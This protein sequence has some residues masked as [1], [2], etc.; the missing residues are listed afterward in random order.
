M[1]TV[2]DKLNELLEL[3]PL[4]LKTKELNSLS[5][6][7]LEYTKNNID[8]MKTLIE[9]KLFHDGELHG[10]K[11]KFKLHILGYDST[12]QVKISYDPDYACIT[13][14]YTVGSF[15]KLTQTKALIS[16][17]GRN[18]EVIDESEDLF[19]AIRTDLEVFHEQMRDKIGI[20][21]QPIKDIT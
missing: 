19:H 1:V 14:H 2:A 4:K 20:L 16:L 9:T 12:D 18:G 17:K 21:S 13:V 11:F 3:F 6:N 7:E 8:L 5:I 10:I 15:S